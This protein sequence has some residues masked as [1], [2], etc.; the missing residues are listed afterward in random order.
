[1]AQYPAILKY[2][3]QF[4]ERLMPQPKEYTGK[5]WPGRKA[6]TY[7][8]YE[9]QD[10][11]DYYGEFERGK[12]VIPAIVNGASYA[13]DL[14]GSYSNDKTSII[15]MV[16]KYLLGLLNSQ[17][18]DFVLKQISS[19][20][21]GGYFEYKPMYVSVLPIIPN[22]EAEVKAKI[23]SLVEQVLVGKEKGVDTAGLEEEIDRVVFGLYGLGDGEIGI[24][25]G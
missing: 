15:P 18:V 3:E 20:K 4:K 2:L 21:R 9:I 22:P 5:D 6:G 16:D 23:E 10:A 19:T 12:I 8:W 13:F 1:M 25:E 14:N 17:L 7:K 11:V 24:V